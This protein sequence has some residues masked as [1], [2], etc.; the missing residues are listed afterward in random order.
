M[1]L[2]VAVCL[3]AALIALGEDADHGHVRA[4]GLVWGTTLGLALAHTFAFRVSAR[5]AAGGQFGRSDSQIV[6]A[7]LA[8]ATFVAV[9]ATLPVV[10]FG[11]TGEFDVVRTVLSVFIGATGYAVGRLSGATR[12]RSLVYGAVVLLLAV[13]IAV[14]KNILS[15]H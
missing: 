8:G 10:L 3:L 7:Q 2:Y 11:P 15:G 13:V 12:T 14:I 9:I 5:L 6:L 1:A 4:F